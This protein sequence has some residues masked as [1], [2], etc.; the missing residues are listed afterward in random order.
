MVEKRSSTDEAANGDLKRLRAND[1][2]EPTATRN[3]SVAERIAAIK[4]RKAQAASTNI[5]PATASSPPVSAQLN[6]DAAA[7]IA[8]I[9]A[10]AQ[11][12]ASGQH[13]PTREV[14]PADSGSQVDA[15]RQEQ[16][17]A[18]I[19]AFTS[20]VANKAQAP[21]TDAS[22]EVVEEKQARARGGLGVGLHPALLAAASRPAPKEKAGEERQRLPPANPYLSQDSSVPDADE[23]DVA[24]LRD[25]ALAKQRDRRARPIQFNQKGKFIAQAEALRAEERLAKLD[26]ELKEQARQ[27]EIEEATERSFLVK[28]PPAVE[29]WDVPILVRDD[30]EN[31]DAP[32]AIQ[33]DAITQ[34][35]Q[36][37]ILLDPPQDRNAPK[38]K[39][40]FLTKKEQAKLRRQR[41]MADH[42]EEQ[43]KVR[44]GLVDPAPPKVKKSNLMRVLGQ[45]A[46]K[47]PT[48]VELRVN[49]EIEQRAEDHE[50]RNQARQLTSEQRH[51]KLAAQQE[52]DVAQGVHV[53]VFRVEN[54]S[55][56]K[57][58]FQIDKNA[59]QS[60]LTGTVVL[61]PSMNLVV[62]E[63]G[64][65]SIKFYK[66]LMLNRIK[67]SE[68]A[69]PTQTERNERESHDWLQALDSNGALK[70]LSENKCTLVWEGNNKTRAFKKWDNKVC[71]TDGQ[72]KNVL[73]RFHMENL[74]TR[75]QNIHDAEGGY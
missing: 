19:A 7:R 57:H 37:P 60:A 71:E 1:E 28:P 59:Q 42:K 24:A 14:R 70:D 53:C 72:A 29:W 31:L 54:L 61:H 51:E 13:E 11:S 32:N 73:A 6:P 64:A 26:R 69:Q 38:A 9:K 68:N 5:P 12:R 55:Y 33:P 27:K 39:A 20:R 45:E 50:S 56:R 63:G 36:H 35:I 3:L 16:I 23:G 21:R 49:R 46:V 44:L 41:R 10:K 48:A 34:Y 22:N 8:A 52:A 15:A 4:A 30:Y 65:H 25:P 43:A 62:A 75:A 47:D 74:W 40:M 17:K 66:K 2:P 58:R 18:Q 67:W